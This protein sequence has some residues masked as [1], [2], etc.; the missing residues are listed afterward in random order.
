MPDRSAGISGGEGRGGEGHN[1]RRACPCSTAGGC[2]AESRHATP[3]AHR[4]AAVSWRAARIAGLFAYRLQVRRARDVGIPVDR[5][6]PTGDARTAAIAGVE[7][8]GDEAEG[9]EDKENHDAEDRV[10]WG[11]AQ[12]TRPVPRLRI[13]VLSLS[14]ADEATT[15]GPP[16]RPTPDL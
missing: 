13:G 1:V 6:D 4:A 16:V 8:G 3:Y 12:P 9:Y 5:V 14:P 11:T 10:T 7:R 15:E 2:R